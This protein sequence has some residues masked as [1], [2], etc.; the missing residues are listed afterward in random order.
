[1]AVLREPGRVVLMEFIARHYAAGECRY[2]ARKLAPRV[3]ARCSRRVAAPYNSAADRNHRNSA[4]A[5]EASEGLVAR[6]SDDALSPAERFLPLALS[7][8][9]ASR[10][11]VADVVV[12]TAATSDAQQRPRDLPDDPSIH[13]RPAMDDTCYSSNQV[14][15]PPKTSPL[16]VNP[17]LPLRSG[18]NTSDNGIRTL[19]Y[20]LVNH[21]VCALS[22]KFHFSAC[23][24]VLTRGNNACA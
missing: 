13:V 14:S 7:S 9:F 20:P 10:G 8:D 24:A 4:A 6:A 2:S 12:D 19:N 11:A 18:A 15:R 21:G 1:M 22:S 3:T 16:H 17:P 5:G 23:R